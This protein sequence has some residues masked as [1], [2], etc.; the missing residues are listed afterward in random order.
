MDPALHSNDGNDGKTPPDEIGE[1]V[2]HPIT[3]ELDLHCFRPTEIGSLLP[4]YFREC[5]RRGMLRVRVV[6]GKGTGALREG[7]LRLLDRL[8]EVRDYQTGDTTG[9]GWGATWVTLAPWSEK[10]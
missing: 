10:E 5:R 7:V 4:E 8:P 3:D 6:H 1:A 9:G 2:E